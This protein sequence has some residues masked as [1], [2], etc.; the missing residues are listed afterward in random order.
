MRK[1]MNDYLR[2]HLFSRDDPRILRVREPTIDEKTKVSCR[3]PRISY[4]I[5]EAYNS[6]NGAMMLETNYRRK[7]PYHWLVDSSSDWH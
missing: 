5:S 3:V 7:V 2:N 4:I 1:I 6:P